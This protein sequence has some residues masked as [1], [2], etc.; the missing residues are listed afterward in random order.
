MTPSFSQLPLHT[1]L[2]EFN[3]STHVVELLM[4]IDLERN[5]LGRIAEVGSVIVDPLF[6]TEEYRSLIHLVSDVSAKVRHGTLTSQVLEAILPGGSITGAPKL[7]AIAILQEL[8]SVP[9]GVYTGCI[10]YVRPG[11]TEFNLAIRTMVHQNGMYQLH[12]G[13]GIV[14]DSAPEA[15]YQE[16]MLKAS[17]ML[18]AVGLEEK[19]LECLR[20]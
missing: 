20:R 13:G 2:A 16:M 19:G 17:N 7:R 15:E 3:P 11:Q 12:A 9:R 1:V 5:D 18:R 10:G 14:A 6:R 4:I 8:E